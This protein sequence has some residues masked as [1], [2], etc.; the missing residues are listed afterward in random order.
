MPA[1]IAYAPRGCQRALIAVLALAGAVACRAAPAIELTLR[2]IADFRPAP[3]APAALPDQ[4]PHS[5][6]AHG[7]RDIARA[8]LAAPTRR[9]AHAVLGDDLEAGELRVQTREG[10]TLT[11]R[12]PVECVF[13][14]L[15]PRLMDLDGDGRDEIVVVES[16]QASGAMISIWGVDAGRLMRKAAGGAIG[17]PHRWLNPIGFGNFTGD[18][19]LDIAVVQTPHIGGIVKIYRLRGSGLTL[20]AERGQ[21]STHAL[22]STELALGRVFR[23]GA[24]TSPCSCCVAVS[25]VGWP[26]RGS[27][28]EVSALSAQVALVELRDG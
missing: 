15:V 26:R 9:Y 17:T 24:T 7:T 28:G 18:G 6:V 4:L 23:L 12:L 8:W 11:A 25:A 3:R 19:T 21:Y 5:D 13:E 14:D 27:N 22:G 2:E 10:A 20:L 16:C 1:A